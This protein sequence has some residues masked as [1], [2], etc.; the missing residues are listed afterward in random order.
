MPS[1]ID[2]LKTQII[3]TYGTPCSVIDLDVVDR[4][5]ARVQAMCDAAGVRNR[6]HIKTHKSPVLAQAQ[7]DAGAQGITCQKLGEAKVMADAGIDDIIIATNLLGAARSG[8]LAKLQ[9]KVALWSNV[10][11][12]TNEQAWKLRHKRLNWRG[13]FAMILG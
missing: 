3:E 13:L 11:R 10:T 12:A 9:S 8:A 6:P 5:I 1:D 7:L 2:R 4:N